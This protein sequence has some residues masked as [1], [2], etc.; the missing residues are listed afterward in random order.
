M[1]TSRPDDTYTLDRVPPGSYTVTFSTPEGFLP[2]MAGGDSLVPSTRVTV[3]LE[4]LEQ[5]GI[6]AGFRAPGTIAV[7]KTVALDGDEATERSC[8]TQ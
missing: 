1:T 5:T 7:S 4:D 6:D 8:R 2:T 3:A